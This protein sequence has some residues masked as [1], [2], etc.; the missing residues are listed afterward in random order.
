[1][2]YSSSSKWEIFEHPPYSPDLTPSDYH[3]FLHLKKWLSSQSMRSEQA[4]EYVVQDWLNV[5]VVTFFNAGIQKLGLQ[6]EQC[7]NLHG[8][9]V[10]K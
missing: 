8:D 3:L 7:L 1:V 9:Y 4:T 2:H 5:L 6:Y 10:E